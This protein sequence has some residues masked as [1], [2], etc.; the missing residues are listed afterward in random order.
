MLLAGLVDQI[1]LPLW[2]SQIV[3]KLNFAQSWPNL[4]NE[5]MD[6]FMPL[7]GGFITLDALD[8]EVLDL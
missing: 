1:K 2:P 8:D 4:S 7:E 6:P 3:E 5:C